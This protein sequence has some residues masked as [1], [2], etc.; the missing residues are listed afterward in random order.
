M[1]KWLNENYGPDVASA[2][3]RCEAID[4]P[5]FDRL[6]R[7]SRGRPSIDDLRAAIRSLSHDVSVSFDALSTNDAFIKTERRDHLLGQLQVAGDALKV[8]DRFETLQRERDEEDG[9]DR[10][11]EIKENL[12][13][14][15]PHTRILGTSDASDDGGWILTAVVDNNQREG[16]ERVTGIPDL[17]P[18][19]LSE[20][21]SKRPSAEVAKELAALGMKVIHSGD[22]AVELQ[23]AL[24]QR[25]QK[26][27]K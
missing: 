25:F 7:S 15:V 17:T 1:L 20:W 14:S 27:R 6:E 19:Q 21:A 22:P 12:P 23:K 8:L 4:S 11:E 18:Q 10:L 5:W 24:A 26:N 2:V 16:L 13:L 9:R 3:E